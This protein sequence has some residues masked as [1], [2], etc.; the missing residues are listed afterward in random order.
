MTPRA[1]WFKA[2]HHHRKQERAWEQTRLIAT[3]LVNQNAKK[4]KQI[5]AEKLL[6]LHL[7]E[8]AGGGRLEGE[9]LD[10][11]LANAREFRDK[12]KGNGANNR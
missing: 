5:K 7:D 2:L 10:R 1:F 4:G 9:E 6:P 11:F 3:I 8:L 12:T